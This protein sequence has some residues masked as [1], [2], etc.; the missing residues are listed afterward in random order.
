MS[1]MTLGGCVGSWTLGLGTSLVLGGLVLFGGDYAKAQITPDDTL[2]KEASVVKPNV[3]INGQTSDLIEGGA[4]R[5]PNLFHS[6]LEFNVG[7]GRGAYFA[8]PDGIQNILGRV[9]GTNPSDILGTLGVQGNANL[10]LLNPNGIIFGPNARLDIPGSFVASTANSLEFGNGEKFSATNPEAPPL[11][12]INI[13]PGLQYG[14]N[15]P[16][17]TI[18]N[19]GNLAVG[20]DLTLAAGN[21]DL[22]GQLQAGRNLTLLATDTVQVRD[23][24]GNP[25]IASAG[26]QLLV[27][28]NQRV[29]IFALNH[30]DSGLFSGG[31]MVLRSASAVGGDAHYWSGGNFRIEQLE[32]S[33]GDL[34][35]PNDPVI[36]ASGDVSFDS[37][38]GASLHIF[39]GGSVNIKEGVKITSADVTNGLNETVT[40]S[41]GTSLEIKGKTHPTLDIRAGTTAIA[42]PE[43]IDTIPPAG[44]FSPPEPNTN[45]LATS[46]DITIGSISN[47]GGVVFLTNQ[48]YPNTSLPGGVIQVGKIDTSSHLSNALISDG[49]SVVIDSRSSINL[50]GEVNSSTGH[51]YRNGGNITLIAND[52]ITT[53]SLSSGS[54][55]VDTSLKGGDIRLTSRNGAINTAGVLSS[56]SF[57]GTSGNIILTANGSITTAQRLSSV[58]TDGTSGNITLT[59]NGSITAAQNLSSLSI[60]GT[61]GKITLTA[62]GNIT[63]GGVI[64]ASSSGDSGDI[65]FNSENGAVNTIAGILNSNSFGKS[66]SITLIAATD[67]ITGDITSTSLVENGGNI[68]L[69]SNQGIINTTQGIIDSHSTLGRGGNITF[70]ANDNITTQQINSYSF[71]SDGGDISLN[72]SNGAINTTKGGLFSSSFHIDSTSGDITFTAKGNITTGSVSTASPGNGGNIRF[73][74]HEGGINTTADDV[75]SSSFNQIGGNVTFNANENIILRNIDASGVRLGGNITLRSNNDVLH[76]N[77]GIVSTASGNIAI[78]ARNLKLAGGSRLEAG[79]TEVQLGSVNSS[80]GNIEIN[81]T[82]AVNLADKSAIANLIQPGAEGKGGNIKITASSFSATNGSQLAT[83]TLGEGPAGNV[84]LSANTISFE[85]ESGVLTSVEPGAKGN[86]GEIYIKATSLFMSNGS[87]LQAS[88]KGEGNAGNVTLEVADRISFTGSKNG[89]SSGVTSTSELRAVGNSSN[90]T[91]NT[92]QLDIQDGGAVTVSSAGGGK[93]GNIGITAENIFLN[94]EGAIS[95]STLSVFDGGN[96]ILNVDKLLVLRRGSQISTSAGTAQ[97][98]GNG[99]NIIIKAPEGFIIGIL[100][101]NSDITANAFEGNGGNINITTQRIFGLQERPKLTDKSDITASSEIGRDGEIGI[102]ELALNPNNGL[103]SLPGEPLPEVIEPKCQIG[104]RPGSNKFTVIGRGGLPPNPTQT[105]DNNTV[106]VDIRSDTPGTE[107]SSSSDGDIKPTRSAPKQI[108]EAQGWIIN[109]EGKV[110]L[111]AVAPQAT[112]P[113]QTP[114][115]CDSQSEKV[116]QN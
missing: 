42:N 89:F 5:G 40:L 77:G 21:L 107:N 103:A 9:T 82:E 18:A 47:E 36:R 8:N 94:T 33:L 87:Q 99:G 93:A 68:Y 76:T 4:T 7:E 57:K 58:S 13:T 53:A 61:G 116:A 96:I 52:D 55:D 90:I 71:F 48:Y 74:S 106:W 50:T 44:S 15:Q 37:Y 75:I 62:N 12:T 100:H 54:I 105:I 60:N 88:T 20:Q 11:L 95:A 83:S 10:F 38:E 30:P 23:S 34:E 64:S 41:D 6:F 17:G 51:S 43:I 65:Y 22:Q 29:D 46:A 97:S 114:V 115:A 25:F 86:G 39:A 108:V 101:E 109:K 32:G 63:T 73:I 49:G 24:V 84:T 27:Q 81:V 69:R 91:I 92:R 85:N 45:A 59:A 66:G 102:S 14:A 104:S 31:N 28:G 67:L 56:I 112:L 98:G 1:G 110:E 78:D 70:I 19:T 72:S 111:V 35:S 2:G 16:G 80:S 3:N 79:R 113:Q 26:E